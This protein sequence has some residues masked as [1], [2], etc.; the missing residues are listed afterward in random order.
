MERVFV[1]GTLKK[2]QPN[3][4]VISA[5]I[6]AGDCQFVCLGVTEAKYPLVIAS[7]YNFPFLLDAPNAENAQVSRYCT[8]RAIYRPMPK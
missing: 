6:K 5:A 3:H 1:Y 8:N 7:D 2:D 4:H